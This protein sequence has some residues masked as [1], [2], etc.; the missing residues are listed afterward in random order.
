MLIGGLLALLA[1]VSF[2]RSFSLSTFVRFPSGRLWSSAVAFLALAFLALAFLALA[3]LALS[4]G[5]RIGV[6]PFRMLA[7]A[8]ATGGGG[9]RENAGSGGQLGAGAPLRT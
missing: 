7:G 6:L 9:A 4:F 8:D 5:L 2:S 1:L 3:F